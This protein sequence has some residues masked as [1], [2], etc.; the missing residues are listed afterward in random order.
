M[1]W[2]LSRYTADAV[3]RIP[4]CS[5]GADIESDIVR[6]EY[7]GFALE[8]DCAKR[9]PMLAY[10]DLFVRGLL[11][12]AREKTDR[13]LGIDF[14]HMVDHEIHGFVVHGLKKVNRRL[15]KGK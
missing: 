2:L 9:C 14:N 7:P 11:I 13:S 3:C 5:N 6:K 8:T 4:T 1:P 12:P 15:Q 10:H